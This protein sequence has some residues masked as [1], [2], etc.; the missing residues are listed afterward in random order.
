[1]KTSVRAGVWGQEPEKDWRAMRWWRRA[2]G[3]VRVGVG[4]ASGTEEALGVG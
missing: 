3:V 4:D 1:V 2:A